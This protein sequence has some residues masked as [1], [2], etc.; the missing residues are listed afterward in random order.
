MSATHIVLYPIIEAAFCVYTYHPSEVGDG[1][2]ENALRLK[3][4]TP[5]PQYPQRLR[6]RGVLKTMARV[7]LGGRAVLEHGQV[8]D[9]PYM[10]HAR[11]GVTVHPVKAGDIPIPATEI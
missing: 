7:N 11:M 1:H 6:M 8:K 4:S 9:I 2:I 10:L 5:F 3:D